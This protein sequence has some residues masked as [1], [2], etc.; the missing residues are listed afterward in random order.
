MKAKVAIIMGSESDWR[1]MEAAADALK[2][3][4]IPFIVEV[5]SAPP[6]P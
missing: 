5:V 6:H 4:S 1:V 3:F 2:E